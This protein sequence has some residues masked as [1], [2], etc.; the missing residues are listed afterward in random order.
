MIEEVVN[1][2][3]AGVGGQGVVLT[4]HIIAEAAGEEGLDV[5]TAETMGVSQRGG[6]VISHI[7]MGEKVYS[8]LIPEG[9]ARAFLGFEPLE[10]LRVAPK[11]LSP[12]GYVIINSR[13]IVPLPVKLG[14]ANYPSLRQVM[15]IIGK[16]TDRAY[17]LDATALAAEAGSFRTMG[18]V[19]LGMLSASGAIPLSAEVLRSSVE[20]NVPKRTIDINLRAFELGREELRNYSGEKDEN[21]P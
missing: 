5:T 11:Y 18:V 10:A 19:M 16:I 21:H 14:N 15:D 8:V 7:R 1:L 4:T 12:G 13:A 20:R 6:S 9:E 17:A 2:V 3:I